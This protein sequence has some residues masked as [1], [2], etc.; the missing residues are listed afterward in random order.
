MKKKCNRLS[1]PRW[2]LGVMTWDVLLQKYKENEEAGSESLGA[3]CL[4][5]PPLKQMETPRREV[6]SPLLG[7]GS[8]LPLK[9]SWPGRS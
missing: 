5:P 6:P 2:A 4:S 1:G 7:R 9:M 3:L 8:P